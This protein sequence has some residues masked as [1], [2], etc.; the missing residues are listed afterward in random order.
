MGIVLADSRIINVII[1][2]TNS[3]EETQELDMIELNLVTSGMVNGIA[4][5]ISDFD[6]NSYGRLKQVLTP[7]ETRKV[8]YPY[9]M[10]SLWFTK[11]DWYLFSF[12][13]FVF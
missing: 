2:L 5:H 1:T 13:V 12:A 6:N 3:T 4:K 11:K 7:G 9:E 8:T 10:L